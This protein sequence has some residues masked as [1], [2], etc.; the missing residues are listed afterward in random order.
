M[1]KNIN[2]LWLLLLIISV[3]MVSCIGDDD[4]DPG[5]VELGAGDNLPEFSVVM[6][7]G[8]SVTSES[9][10]GKTS[11]IVFFNTGCPDCRA[12]LPVIQRVYDEYPQLSIVCISR[13]ERASS[14]ADYWKA[15]RLTLPYSA[16]E[17]ADI[18]HLF[19]KSQIPRIY[20]VDAD[21]IIRQVFTDK[22]LA[23]F[24]ALENEILSNV[25]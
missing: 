3:C 4:P 22:P 19:A 18:Y 17:D 9:L 11:L 6:N 10:R 14:I 21:L 1:K 15:N 25:F 2:S 20:V 8:R 24:E 13:D 5:T 16:Q 23:T 7:D 12:E